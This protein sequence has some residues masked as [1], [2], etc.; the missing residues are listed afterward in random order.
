MRLSFTK[1]NLHQ[2]I[3]TLLDS[4]LIQ[5]SALCGTYGLGVLVYL[6]LH[7]TIGEQF[8]LVR[9]ANNF[10]H[11]IT[12]LCFPA[13]LITLLTKR[14][15]FPWSLYLVPGV[16]VFLIWHGGDF[17]P[18]FSPYRDSSGI[19]L[20]VVSYN[21]VDSY[22]T[23]TLVTEDYFDADIVGLQEVP[24]QRSQKFDSL[25]QQD[26]NAI[27]TRYPVVGD[28]VMRVKATGDHHSVATVKIEVDIE[29]YTI[30]IYSLHANRPI[31]TFRPFVFRS[32]TRKH[33]V[34]ALVEAVANDPNPVIV[35]CDCNF[36]EQTDDYKLMATY[37]NDAWKQKGFG[38]GLT[39]PAPAGESNSLFPII[40]TDHI[41]YTDEFEAVDVEVLPLAVSDHY[42]VMAHIKFYPQ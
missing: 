2:I 41:W 20:K 7:F 42:P 40:R 6:I 25:S 22:E 14:Y 37:L 31:L 4:F 23:L 5:L 19:D 32:E 38:L 26:T 27:Y 8:V 10:A 18:K 13:L 34:E 30:S 1:Q 29:G 11:L 3:S 24:P 16:I 39:A 12:L 9:L 35:F 33:D 15:R 21:I 28:K 36:S 17:I